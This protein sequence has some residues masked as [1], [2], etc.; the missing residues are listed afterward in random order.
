MAREYENQALR[1]YANRKKRY[2]RIRNFIICILLLA[3]ILV[4]AIY[5]TYLYNKSYKNYK[6]VKSTEVSSD[7][8]VGY[9]SYGSSVIKYGKDGAIAYDKSGNVL[10]N[11]SYNMSDPITDICEQYVVIADRGGKSVNV[12]N[13]KG[14]AASYETPYE[15]TKVEV[16]RQGVVAALMEEGDANYIELYDLDRTLLGEAGNTINNAGFPLD[17]SLSNDGKKL[18]L[19]CLS[20]TK[21]DLVSFLACYNFSEVGDNY[22]NKF[23]GGGNFDKGIVASKVEFLNNNTFCVFKDNGFMLY[24]MKEI[25]S[26]IKEIKLEGNIQS[27][28]YNEKYVGVVLETPDG[29][30]RNLKVYNLKGKLVLDKAIDFEYKQIYITDEEIIMYNDLSSVIMKMNGKIKFSHTFKSN[31]TGFYPI[32]NLDHYYLISET[33]LSDVQLAD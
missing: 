32:N 28:L 21:G 18:G 11:G 27:I 26:D 20:I 19:I 9:L 14:K 25:P 24:S 12:Y 16:A 33:K 5:I 10:W 13:N 31:I 1:E 17:M 7:G 29:S 8:T 2:K 23:V 4:G 22:L 6:V 30:S 3:V 15:I